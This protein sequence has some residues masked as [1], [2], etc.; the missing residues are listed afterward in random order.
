MEIRMLES[1]SVVLHLFKDVEIKG[2]RNFPQLYWN[3]EDIYVLT[4][5]KL[6]LFNIPPEDKEGIFSCGFYWPLGC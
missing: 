2:G 3:T 4:D 6:E 5:T 1:I